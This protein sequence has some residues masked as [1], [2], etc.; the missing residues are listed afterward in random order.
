MPE[1]FHLKR[2]GALVLLFSLWFGILS[3]W[4][5]DEKDP[6]AWIARG[7]EEYARMTCQSLEGAIECFQKA[8]SLKPDSPSAHA[9]LARATGHLGA[10]FRREGKG[11]TELFD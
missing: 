6:E 10:L 5:M 8:L 1:Y 2:L 9:W 11:G 4:G 3:A 7:K